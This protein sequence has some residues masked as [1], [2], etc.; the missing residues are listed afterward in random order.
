MAQLWELGVR[1]TTLDVVAAWK[2]A[3]LLVAILVVAWHVRR[4][5]AVRA[6]DVLA[7]G[8]AVVIIVYWLIPQ[9]WLDGEATTRGELLALRHDLFPVAAYALGRLVSAAWPDRERFGRL[10]ATIAVAVVVVG[11]VDLAFIPLQ[12]WRDSGVPGWYREQLGLDYEGLSGLPENWVFNTGNEESPLRRMV[13]TFLSP[14]ASAYL[15]VVALIYVLSRPFRWWWG[16]L[17]VLLYVGL[18][19]THT[20]A[21]FAALAVG[22]VVL[23]TAQRRPA[24]A[25]LGVVSAVVAALFLS[26]YPSIGPTTSYTQEELE[27]LR[28]NA[29]REG[30]TSGD[31][32]AGNEA[33]TESHWRNLRDGVRVVIEHPQGY[34]LGNAGVVA[35]RT[36]VEIRAGESTYTELGVD[37]GIAGAAAFILW[38]LA[39]LAGLWRREAWLA[40]AFS[41]VLLL[42]LQTDVIGVHW[43]AFTL[44]AA[45]GLALGLPRDGTTTDGDA[46]EPIGEAPA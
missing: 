4:W 17:A 19:F 31:P 26:V 28:Q 5:P 20:R 2:E 15:L 13:S 35:K 24:P 33:S 11:L 12:S 8:Y 40:G 38:S 44:W 39:L 41:A 27:W 43:L 42:A 14:L 21:A 46:P 23:A 18:L 3:I 9:T 34:G 16:L 1:G 6:A 36:G 25:V 22:L 10:I 45:A 7:A 29:A 30:G 32:F 37:A